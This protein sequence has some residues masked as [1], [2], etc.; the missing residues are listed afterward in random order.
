[1]HE[2]LRLELLSKLAPAKEIQSLINVRR[3]PITQTVP[4]DAIEAYL[5]D[6][7]QVDREFKTSIRIK[8]EKPFDIAFEDRVWRLFALVGFDFMNRD[9]NFRLPYDTGNSVLAQQIDVFAKDE[10]TILIVECKAA[11]KN[12]RGDFKKELEAMKGKMDGMLK[13]IRSLYPKKKHKVKFILA[14]HNLAVSEED[15]QRLADIGGVHFNDENIQY[16]YDLYSQI[17]SAC[18]YQLLGYLFEGKDIPEM[19]NRVPAIEGRMGGFR[20]YSFSIEPEKL[21]KLGYVL[22]RNKA[23]VAMM[24]TYQR[25]IKK[26][27]LKSINQFIDSGGYFPNSIVVSIDAERVR[28]DAATNQAP[29]T[30][31]KAG[32]L[33]LPKRYRSL[34]II[35]GQHRLYGYANSK[36][37]STNTIPV[38]AFLNVSRDN[39]VNLFMQINENQKAVSKDLR[40]TLNADLLWDSPVYADQMKAL[41]SRI[42]IYL[43]ENR[44]SPLFDF[45]SIGED[46]KHITSQAI[47]NALKNGG[48]LGKFSKNKFEEPGLLYNGN[49]DETFDKLSR[50]LNHCFTYVSESLVEEWEKGA[51]G[52]LAINKGV[53]GLIMAAGDILVHLRDTHA[54]EIRKATAKELFDEVKHYLDAIIVFISNLD[55]ESK[56]EMKTAYGDRG[57]NLYWRSFRKAIYD[58]NK[59]FFA[60]EVKEWIQK[61]E[62]Q[63]NDSA[64]KLIR[65]IETYMKLDFRERLSE[66]YGRKWFEKGVPP[67]FAVRALEEAHNKNREIEEE[68][69]EV[70]PWDC[71][72]IIVYREIALKN[73]Q[74]IF[75]KHYTRPGE[76]KGGVSKDEKTSWMQRLERIRNQNF[77]SYSVTEEEL[78][79]LEEIHDWLIKKKARNRFQMQEE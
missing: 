23:N 19:E 45:I 14:T 13:T 2:N 31:S 33:Y 63:Y 17:G 52:I 1:M 76:E 68:D 48:F 53:Y 43:G 3:R 5:K 57:S 18:R 79:F 41:S 26:G 51:E 75:E 74:S 4:R 15:A 61:E 32:I 9:R 21:L 47:H 70:E 35:D 27:R 38:V 7:W 67:K 29:S 10:E 69:K 42:A 64:F 34:F 77:H 54:F 37:A 25:L 55:F 12:K 22:H 71:L 8:R 28:F 11:E 72:T 66:Y 16:F 65:D 50:F 62:K 44:A 40:N 73:W 20:Y 46:K 60:D 30:E 78:Q 6:G 36:Y 39:Q 58:H 59:D 56:T 24:P 49:L